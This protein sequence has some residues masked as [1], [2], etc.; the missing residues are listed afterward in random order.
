MPLPDLSDLRLRSERWLT[1]VVLGAIVLR[2]AAAA[3]IGNQFH[4]ADEASYLDTARRLLQGEGFGV[5]FAQTPGYPIFLAM[6]SVLATDSVLTIRLAQA[7]LAGLGTALVYVLAE[8]L[9]G[10]GPALPAAAIYAVDPLLVVSG[11][12]LYPETLAA[13]LVVLAILAAWRAGE[14]S[15]GSACVAGVL[16]G[17]IALVRPVGLVLV[18]AVA[19]WIAL[20]VPPSR[21]PTHIAAVL[22]ATLL[23][24]A[25]WT[26]RNYRIRGH[27]APIAVAGAH[28]AP[29][30]PREVAE[31]GLTVAIVK[32]LWE[33]PAPV[34]ARTAQQFL[35][36]WELTPTRLV[37]DDPQQRAAIHGRDPRVS[38][39]AVVPSRSRDLVSLI[40]SSVEFGL[41]LI[42][43]VLLWRSRRAA[44]LLLSTVTVVFALGYALFV[45]KLRYRIPILPLVFILAGVTV[46]TL[47]SRMRTRFA[48]RTPRAK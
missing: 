37:T 21:A 15:I 26:Y 18:P 27:L 13:I 10:R 9:A 35:Q 36:F 22:G 29:V 2:V 23:V 39:E 17:A 47:G 4:F 16:L 5:A 41:A 7:I 33:D 14:N 42:G 3:V 31:E 40:A 45:A 12:L 11:A 46:C 19:A 48:S 6:L 38:K 8:R 25:P 1:A 44:A 24:L 28:M 20:K 34:V 32:K 43:L 30:T